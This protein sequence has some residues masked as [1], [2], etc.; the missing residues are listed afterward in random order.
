MTASITPL[1]QTYDQAISQHLG[2]IDRY[3]VTW[4]SDKDI[5]ES[6]TQVVQLLSYS[7]QIPMSEGFERAREIYQQS[8]RDYRGNQKLSPETCPDMLDGLFTEAKTKYGEDDASS[9]DAIF[10][11]GDFRA[12]THSPNPPLT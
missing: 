9:L 4:G 10:D 3:Y 11:I 1:A 2:L 7:H 8:L 6:I 12:S 5:R